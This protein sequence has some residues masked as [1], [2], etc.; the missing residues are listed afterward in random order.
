MSS[1]VVPNAL[2]V[3]IATDPNLNATQ[4]TELT[5]L[6]Q[7]RAD[8][9]NGV[10]DARQAAG[11]LLMRVMKL[12]LNRKAQDE[13]AVSK[14]KDTLGAAFTLLTDMF[15]ATACGNCAQYTHKLKAWRCA[16]CDEMFCEP[17]YNI[18]GILQQHGCAEEGGKQC[19]FCAETKARVYCDDEECVCINPPPTGT[20]EEYR[21]TVLKAAY[22]RFELK[23]Q[24]K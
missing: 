21:R 5:A 12:S 20:R 10:E 3:Y 4:R 18:P 22:Q 13:H 16:T 9:R 24:A 7:D 11:D 19:R 15:D 6:I 17:C 23:R 2:L 1:V 14:L 8:G